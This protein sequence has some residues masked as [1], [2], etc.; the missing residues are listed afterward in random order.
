M[1]RK[2]GLILLGIVLGIVIALMLIFTDTW[3]EHRIEH[4]GDSIVGAKVELDGF[5]FSL[6]G[7]HIK[8]EKL[9]VTNP[10]HTMR[11]MVETGFTEFNMETWPLL[12]GRVIIDNIEMSDFRTNTKR[13]KDGA[14]PKSYQKRM[15][16]HGGIIDKTIAR[17]SD[18]VST[19]ISMDI[20]DVTEQLNVDS[21]M[22]LLD[23]KSVEK[24]DSLQSRLK[25]KYNHWESRL[26]DLNYQDD[27]QEI[28]QNLESLNTDQLET[29]DGIRNAIE[30]VTQT[31]DS[32]KQIA[33]E[34]QNTKKDLESDL[35]QARDTLKRVDDWIASD[36]QRAKSL[37]QLP[38]ISAQ[39]ISRFLFGDKVVNQFNQYAG[40]MATAREYLTKFKRDNTPAKKSPPRMEG[41]DIH[42]ATENPRPKFWIKRISLSGET[43]GEL[44]LSGEVHNIVSD[45]KTIG[46][47]TKFQVA[48]QPESGTRFSLDGVLNYMGDSPEESFDLNYSNFSLK[49]SHLSNSPLFPSEI[50][51]GKGS[52]EATLNIGGE[53]LKSTIDFQAH[54]L[55]Y[56][57][58]KLESNS[59]LASMLQSVLSGINSLNLTTQINS[60]SSNLNFSLNSNLDDVLQQNLKSTLVNKIEH[61]QEEI[62]SRIEAKV[63][64]NRNQLQ[65]LVSNQEKQLRQQIEQYDSQSAE[66]QKLVDKKIE[67]LRSKLEEKA[68]GDALD[69]L[70]DLF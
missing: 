45:Q 27:I 57:L 31:R 40:Y 66:A 3:L 63:S 7:L 23:I 11:N 17:L 1:L 69:Q 30:T 58:N 62:R 41:Q 25:A 52:I 64:D 2:R 26:T 43:G 55:Q 28:K 16:R 68:K 18:Q 44:P 6:I 4:A 38:D 37:A 70:K 53:L 14:L 15:E 24:I 48:S 61:A 50:D 13:E 9:Q 12:S 5:D 20:S 19:H 65:S 32:I 54:Q 22:N 8:W 35:K 21:L 49:N 47:P 34:I 46:Q 56:S 39:N 59:R 33:D 36:Y 29:V 51:A 60:D 10:D 42:Y 67:A